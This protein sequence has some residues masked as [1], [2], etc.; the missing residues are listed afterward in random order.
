MKRV[1]KIDSQ[2][3]STQTG[4]SDTNRGTREFQND[5]VGIFQ[6]FFD[7]Q[8]FRVINMNRCN[9]ASVDIDKS[10]NSSDKLTQLRKLANWQRMK[11]MKSNFG[12]QRSSRIIYIYIYVKQIKSESEKT[13]RYIY[14]LRITRCI[15][16]VL[17]IRV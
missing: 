2:F 10:K 4:A 9:R 8:Y 3:G 11:S 13:K 15:P 14:I 12:I 6:V 16:H 1:I 17:T 5:L 7:R